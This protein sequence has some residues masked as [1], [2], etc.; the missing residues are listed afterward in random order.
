MKSFSFTLKVEGVERMRL[1]A[2]GC[3]KAN[4]FGQVKAETWDGFVPCFVETATD[5]SAGYEL[6][7]SCAGKTYACVG[8]IRR[9]DGKII[10]DYI[11]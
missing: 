7:D 9:N 5:S 3:P 1:S 2:N 8:H 4:I 6:V 10:L 11:K